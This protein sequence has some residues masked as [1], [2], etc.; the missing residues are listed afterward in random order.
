MSDNLYL[1]N[2]NLTNKHHKHQYTKE[3]VLEF[4]K[5]ARDIEYF[6]EK[7][8]TIVHV[9]RGKIKIPLYDYQKTLLRQFER[10]RFNIVTQ[11]RQSGKTTTTTVFVLHYLLFSKDKTIAILA[12]K[13]DTSQEILSRIQ[14]AFELIPTWL[15]PN[16]MEWNKRTI[17][18]DNG[19]RVIAR[20]TSSS[21][22]RGQSVSLLIIDEAAFVENWEEF[23]KSTYPTIASGKETK[24]ILISTINK[25][26]HFHAIRT[27][28]EQGK[29]EF[30]PFEVKWDDVP[31][32]DQEWKDQTISNTSVDDFMQEHEN[33]AMGSANTL[34][35]SST[36]ITIVP[37][38]PVEILQDVRYYNMP[39]DGHT[40]LITVDTSHGRGLDYSVSSVF[41]ISNY[42]VRQVAV[43]R[44]NDLTPAV[45][46][47]I[48]YN[49]GKQYNLA[50][51]LVE[52][53]DVGQSVVQQL[54][55]EYE[56]ENLINEDTRDG[57]KTKY[58]LGVRT[59][60]QT[61][62]IGCSVLKDLLENQ[63]LIIQDQTTLFELS[64]FISHASSY[65]AE[66]GSHDDCVMTLVMMAWY[67]T[68][69]N[70]VGMGGFD[71]KDLYADKL[72]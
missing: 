20:A 14:L 45:Y 33:I 53:N 58:V 52:S 6:A 29:N 49:L 36:L 34:V 31:D 19:C 48:I 57:G 13:G 10:E 63:K 9:D 40:Y 66:K 16:V 44:S 43:F 24:V 60:S 25:L 2:F 18:F 37:I 70:F 51:V 55:Y 3:Q 1:N 32:R 50:Y 41:D 68:K 5:C 7:Y 42:P 15:K 27:K 38:E 71:F 12:N 64:N 30:V 22:I 61:K 17:E 28:A 56:Y 59:T 4:R 62:R 8:F 23:Y 69:E 54:N 26:N 72:Q 65:R 35:S 21:S 46:P 11:S 39:I 47:R 67:T